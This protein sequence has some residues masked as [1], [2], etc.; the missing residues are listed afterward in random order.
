[1]DTPQEEIEEVTIPVIPTTVEV[2]TIPTSKN[3]FNGP[4][5]LPDQQT[6]L[7]FF[8]KNLPTTITGRSS[9]SAIT[10]I[11][12]SYANTKLTPTN[13]FANGIT[14]DATNHRFI[15]V[16]AGQYLVSVGVGYANTATAEEIDVMIYI[17]GVQS[18]I[19][20][21]YTPGSIQAGGGIA[22][23]L[24]LNTGDYI[25]LYTAH[26][27]ASNRSIFNDP[28]LTYLSISKQ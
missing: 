1:M 17:N 16:T 9:G 8:R 3:V 4:I 18:R 12:G 24:N 7:E 5:S 21:S 22:D 11:P 28:K 15:V 19:S 23:I 27:N 6:L 13:E 10:S 2:P 26:S 14:W 20:I 25:E